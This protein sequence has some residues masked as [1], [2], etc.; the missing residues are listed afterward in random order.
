MRAVT[1]ELLENIVLPCMPIFG[2]ILVYIYILYL[3]ICRIFITRCVHGI[4][5]GLNLKG[6]SCLEDFMKTRHGYAVFGNGHQLDENGCRFEGQVI[7]TLIYIL[8][9]WLIAVWKRMLKFYSDSKARDRNIDLHTA[10]FSCLEKDAQVL[11]RLN[12]SIHQ[13]T[14]VGCDTSS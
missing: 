4:F 3:Y 12:Y 1:T 9:A 6:N 8:P 11:F 7:E 2:S 13:D 10:C 14:G 5:Y